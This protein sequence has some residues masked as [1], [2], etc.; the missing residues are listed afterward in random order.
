MK[1]HLTLFGAFVTTIGL[2]VCTPNASAESE[3]R[4]MLEVHVGPYLPRIDDQ[5]EAATPYAE[6]FGTEGAQLFGAHL[7]YQVFQGFGSLAIGG[8]L[9]YGSVTGNAIQGDGSAATDET[10]L[11]LM[12]A[13][14]SLT[15]RFDWP[16]LTFGFPL[17]PY[18]K[19]GGS[20]T[21]WWMTNGRGEV[22]NA[23]DPDGVGR[24]GG[25]PPG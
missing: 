22:A 15:Y 9:R 2:L 5:F 10:G 19:A 13:T 14:L 3:R 1:S 20:Y 21:I 25:I 6:A 17:V 16:A 23:Y 11:H 18:A 8:G 24:V 7:D 12:P 4:M